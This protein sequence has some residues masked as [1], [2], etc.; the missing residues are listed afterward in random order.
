MAGNDNSE[1]LEAARAAGLDQIAA[2]FPEDVVR[3]FEFA[4]SLHD[5]M[6]CYVAPSDEPAH[7]YRAGGSDR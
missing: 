2:Q 3:A 1:A 7:V 4:K 5:R 6:T